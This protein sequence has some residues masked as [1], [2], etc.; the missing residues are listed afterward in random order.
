VPLGS[1]IQL[2]WAHAQRC[3]T[4]TCLHICSPTWLLLLYV[5]VASGDDYTSMQVC[6]EGWLLVVP[7]RCIAD[8][9]TNRL[10]VVS[11]SGGKQDVSNRGGKRAGSGYGRGGSQQLTRS[12]SYAT[13]LLAPVTPHAG[14]G[15][16]YLACT[17]GKWGMSASS[18]TA[19]VVYVHILKVDSSMSRAACSV[20]SY[21]RLHGLQD[22]GRV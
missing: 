17:A 13:T 12:T 3:S 19:E 5:R 21:T 8:Q 22:T 15:C 7:F 9:M 18:A 11:S 1:A 16:V 20:V 14:V 2:G 4:H 6:V 10:H